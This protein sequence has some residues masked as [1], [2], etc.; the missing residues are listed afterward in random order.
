[1]EHSDLVHQAFLLAPSGPAGRCGR[2]VRVVGRARHSQ[3]TTQQ[4][5]T[6]T[7]RFSGRCLLRV[8]EAAPR[9][10]VY[11]NLSCAKKAVAFPRTS[12]VFSSSRTLRRSWASS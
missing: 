12:T 2:L 5:N 11:L 6:V 4:R 1:M 7:C 9:G 3:R 8:D 10:G